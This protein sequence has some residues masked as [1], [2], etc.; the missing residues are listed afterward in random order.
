MWT[1]G[2]EKILIQCQA[3][4]GNQWTTI[5]TFLP[6]RT[7]NSAKNYFYS[8]LRRKLRLYNQTKRIQE[9]IH[10][11]VH[12]ISLDPELTKAILTTIDHRDFSNENL[13]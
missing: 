5:A 9:R 8:K 6:G 2:E 11:S 4:Y 7:D 13:P 1:L 12:E 10:Q 3:S